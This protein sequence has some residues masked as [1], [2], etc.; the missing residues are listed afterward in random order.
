MKKIIILIITI[1]L[2]YVIYSLVNVNKLNYVLIKDIYYHNNYII[3][4]NKVGNFNNYFNCSSI[5]KLYQ[6]IRNNRTIKVNNTNYYLKKVLRESDE[7]IISVGMEELANN[8]DKYDMSKNYDYFNNLYLDIER[9]I[10]EIKKYAYGKVVFLGLYNPTNYYDSSIDNFFYI[11]ND[12]LNKLMI[13][14]NIVY[15]D[16]YEL[17]KNKL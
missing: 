2:I 7:L 9:L 6:D 12:K 10:K 13:N 4:I 17:E 3:D 15:I 16:I 14:N 1:F 11:I 5:K 8:F